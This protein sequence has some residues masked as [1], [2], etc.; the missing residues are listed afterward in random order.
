M[1]RNGA[2]AILSEVYNLLMKRDMD[3]AIACIESHRERKR[4]NSASKHNARLRRKIEA[5]RVPLTEKTP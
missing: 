5:I 2:A 3:G 1:S 4:F